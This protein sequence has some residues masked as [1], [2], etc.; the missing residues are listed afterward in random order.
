MVPKHT[1][2]ARG[3]PATI[4]SREDN[5]ISWGCSFIQKVY[6]LW[7]ISVPTVSAWAQGM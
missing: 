2:I 1:L 5:P 6:S 4:L 7:E 3:K